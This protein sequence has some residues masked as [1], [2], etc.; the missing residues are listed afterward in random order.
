LADIKRSNFSGGNIEMKTLK[1]S[2]LETTVAL[3]L[4]GGDN[5]QPVCKQILGTRL[6]KTLIIAT[7]LAYPVCGGF[8]QEVGHQT[9]L[10]PSAQNEQQPPLS[11]TQQHLVQGLQPSRPANV[12]PLMWAFSAIAE[13]AGLL[14]DANPIMWII[15]GIPDDDNNSAALFDIG[16]QFNLLQGISLRIDPTFSFGFNPDISDSMTFFEFELPIGI[17][18]FPFSISNEYIQP[19]FFGAYLVPGLHYTIEGDEPGLAMSVGTI[20]EAGYQLRLANRIAITPAVG[21]KAP[22]VT[23]HSPWPGDAPATPNIRLSIGFWWE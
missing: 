12:T 6:L 1:T 2:V 21:L 11:L 16:L 14:I 7:L 10:L 20:L 15:W 4:A 3:D 8:T 18:F 9:G 22:N 13:N 5:A 19:I 23:L 17:I